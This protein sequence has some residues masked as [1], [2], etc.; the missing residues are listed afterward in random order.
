MGSGT[1]WPR[2]RLK[3]GLG[4]GVLRVKEV[5]V[6]PE[7]GTTSLFSTLG[8]PT[9]SH[10]FFPELV[11]TQEKNKALSLFPPHVFFFF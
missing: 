10:Q 11:A 9:H 3:K 5:E 1:E 6:I 8:T 2:M 4:W 7:C